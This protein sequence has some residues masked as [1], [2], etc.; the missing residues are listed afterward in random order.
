MQKVI[1]DTDPGV[2]DA[3]ALAFLARHPSLQVVGVTTVFGN[4]TIDVTTRNAVYLRDE[5]FDPRV[6]VAQGAADP[7]RR[8]AP[9]PI[10]HIHGNNALG[11]IA[12]PALDSD[13]RERID[14]RSA[15]RFIIDTVRASPNEINLLAVGPLTNLAAAFQEDP[16]IQYLLKGVIVMGGAF[17]Y[18]GA[19]GNIS[20]CAEANISADPDAAD[21]VFASACPVTVLGLDV[22][23]RTIMSHEYLEQFKEGGSGAARLVW[24]VTR[25]YEQFHQDSAGVYGIYVHD[26]STVAY[27]IDPSLYACRRGAICVVTEG[28]AIGQT[29]QKPADMKVPAAAWDVRTK[30]SVCVDVR[31]DDVLELFRRTVL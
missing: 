25:V 28:V 30:H 22:T 15:V 24:D 13:W 3:M 16:Q 14:P 20:P 10:G 4:S 7:I 2:D 27:L 23:Q 31:V 8:K 1:F 18:G 9:A 12:L 5:L 29:I 19:L 17:G 21:I 11:D 6:P 26:P